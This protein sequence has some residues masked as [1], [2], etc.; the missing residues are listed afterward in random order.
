MDNQER[1]ELVDILTQDSLK[2]CFKLWGIEYTE[3]KINELCVNETM[4]E[5]V[6]KNYKQLLKG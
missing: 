1:L 4:R 5:R 3:T 2:R 6:M